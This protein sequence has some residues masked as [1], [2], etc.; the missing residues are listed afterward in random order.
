[1]TVNPSAASLHQVSMY[2]DSYFPA[3]SISALI[4]ARERECN[5]LAPYAIYRFTDYHGSMAYLHYAHSSFEML[6]MTDSVIS[7]NATATRKSA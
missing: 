4:F 2:S 6:Q 7:I 5:F 1:M 3:E